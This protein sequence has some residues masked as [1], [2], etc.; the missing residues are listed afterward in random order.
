M[1]YTQKLEELLINE[2]IP[3]I[4]DALDEI[5]EQIAD[6]KNANDEQKEEIEELREF[7]SDLKDLLDDIASGEIE[8]DE[9]EEIYN[10]IIDAQQGEEEE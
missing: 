10:D 6:E 7:K 4:D 3:D 5:F 1:S 9:C 8:D 2:V